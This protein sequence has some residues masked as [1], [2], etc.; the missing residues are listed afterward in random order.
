MPYISEIISS[1]KESQDV[2]WYFDNYN[3]E[4]NEQYKTKIKECKFYGTF[5][6]FDI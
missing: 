1:L 4:N 2:K 6:N 3:K 5:G